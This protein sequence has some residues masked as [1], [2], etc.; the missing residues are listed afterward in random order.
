MGNERVSQTRCSLG[1]VKFVKRDFGLVE[2]SGQSKHF[3]G[4]HKFFSPQK[5]VNY[6]NKMNQKYI[7]IFCI[8]KPSFVK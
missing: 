3:D 2:E 6:C 8:S 4:P 5:K 1:G 7:I